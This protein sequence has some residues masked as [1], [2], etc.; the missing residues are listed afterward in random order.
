MGLSMLEGDSTKERIIGVLSVTWPLTAK[1]IHNA[2]RK[3]YNLSL[4]YQATYKAIKELTE[5]GILE[6]G[7]EGYIINTEWLIRLGDFSRKIKDQLESIN[8]KREIKTA[9]KMTFKN[10]DEFLKFHVDFIED[11]I[12]KEGKL[13]MVFHYRHVPYAFM[14]SEEHM[15]RLKTLMPKMNWRIISKKDTPVGKWNA[16]QWARFGVK[17]KLGADIF[18]DSLIIMNDYILNIYTRKESIEKWDERVK[19]L[20]KYEVR[21]FI[22]E[23]KRKNTVITMIKDKE[24]ASI[25]RQYG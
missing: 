3:E 4:T 1:K 6:R 14:L 23:K 19:E 25:L 11:I 15:K 21:P 9:S 7:K 10:H 5:E 16:K 17:S 2:L 8:Y 20:A 24:L 12:K 13:D 22:D 18:A